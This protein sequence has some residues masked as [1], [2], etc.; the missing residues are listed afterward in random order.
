MEYFDEVAPSRKTVENTVGHPYVEEWAYATL[1][2]RT[3][4]ALVSTVGKCTTENGTH[5]WAT[6]VGGD[7][8]LYPTISGPGLPWLS[9]LCLRCLHDSSCDGPN[10]GEVRGVAPSSLEG[11]EEYATSLGGVASNDVN[12]T[13]GFLCMGDGSHPVTC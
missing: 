7:S 5:C 12:Y 11:I 3:L 13:L 8:S 1:N 9:S 10:P 4:G 2:V 6:A